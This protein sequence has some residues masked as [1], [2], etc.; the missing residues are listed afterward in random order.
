[1]QNEQLNLKITFI[2]HG[3]N[4]YAVTMTSHTSKD[5]TVYFEKKKAIPMPLNSKIAFNL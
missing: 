5:Q 2:Q 4:N 1:M 3:S